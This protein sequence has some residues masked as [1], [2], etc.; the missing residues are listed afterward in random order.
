MAADDVPASVVAFYNFMLGRY[1]LVPTSVLAA[2][3]M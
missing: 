2:H 1:D 3:N